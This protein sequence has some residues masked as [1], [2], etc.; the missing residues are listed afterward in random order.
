MIRFSVLLLAVTFS[1]VSFASQ[2]ASLFV[3]APGAPHNVG[4]GSGKLLLADINGDGRIDLVTAHLQK[5]FIALQFGDGTGR[6]VAVPGSPLMLAYA[7]GDI[8][9]GDFNSDGSPDLGVTNSDRDAVDIFLN[10]GKARFSRAPDSPFT[11]SSSTEFYTRSLYFADFNEDGKLD[12]ATVNHRRNVLA[13]LLGNGRGGFSTAPEV[14]FSPDK[15]SYLFAA[16]DLFGDID[17][18][19]HVD[20]LVASD[21]MNA[22][23]GS[24][25]WLR[26]NGKG[27]FQ[28]VPGVSFSLSSRPRF[29]RLADINGDRRPDVVLSQ[30]GG[31]V[32][33]FLNSGSGKFTM[34]PG[35]PWAVGEDAWAVAVS[36]VNGDRRGDLVAAT[37]DSVTVLVSARDGF[38][39]AS[40]SPFKAGPG[41]YHLA[42]AD[43][44]SDGRPDVVASSFEGNAVTVLIGK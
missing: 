7:P 3:A 8:K 38:V 19:G 21:E 10:D 34:A 9:L 23:S 26:G 42:V 39:A 14:K 35:S 6:F 33:A 12:L 11:V 44:N 28:E 17:G 30:T 2:Q 25:T 15:S 41:A 4:E 1:L 40:G 24:V 37:V 36:D 13:L 32:G 43:L 18:D 16:G 29:V 20:L 22:E 27:A 31:Q 5:R